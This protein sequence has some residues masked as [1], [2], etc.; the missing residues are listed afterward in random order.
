MA[1]APADVKPAAQQQDITL[2][3]N[4]QLLNVPVA[5]AQAQQAANGQINLKVEK[6]KL[7]EFWGQKDPGH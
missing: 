3:G 5:H 2:I 4:Q 6:A 7:P 1:N